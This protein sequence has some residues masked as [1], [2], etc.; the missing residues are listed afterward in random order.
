[1]PRRLKRVLKRRQLVETVI[2][3]IKTD[4]PPDRN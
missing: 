4:G 2:G 3:R 1:L